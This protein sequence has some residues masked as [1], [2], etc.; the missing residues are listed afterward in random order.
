MSTQLHTGVQYP[1]PAD[2]ATSFGGT[3]KLNVAKSKFQSPA[4][5]AQTVTIGSSLTTIEETLADGTQ[6]KCSYKGDSALD[7]PIAGIENP[8]VSRKQVIA[9]STT[10]GKSIRIRPL[11]RA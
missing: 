8:S 1:K 3:W 10:H 5:I 2:P 4:K 7:T 6:R 11:A 9:L